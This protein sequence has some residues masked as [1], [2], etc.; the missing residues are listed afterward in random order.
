M[1]LLKPI[2]KTPMLI[3]YEQLLIQTSHQ[4]GNLITEQ[5]CGEH[6]PLFL[7]ATHYSLTYSPAHNRTN[8]TIRTIQSWRGHVG[9]LR[10]YLR[11]TNQYLP[12]DSHK[13]VP[14]RLQWR[15]VALPVC[16][17]FINYLHPLQLPIKLLTIHI[18]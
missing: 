4:N 3:P 15:E 12:H 11:S 13:P 2:H 6:N 16:E 7:L 18:Y 9:S 14:I 5:N 8:H 17:Y 10:K 1:S